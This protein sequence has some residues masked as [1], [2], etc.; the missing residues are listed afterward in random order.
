MW[1]EEKG[2]EECGGNFSDNCQLDGGGPVGGGGQAVCG[3][4]VFMTI[5]FL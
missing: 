1:R 4:F 3:R 2:E 5:L